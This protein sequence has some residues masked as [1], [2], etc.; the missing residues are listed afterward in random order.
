M[1]LFERNIVEP[2]VEQEIILATF[3]YI[4]TNWLRNA[5]FIVKIN[6]NKNYTPCIIIEK[7]NVS[8]SASVTRLN[9]IPIYLLNIY[10]K[11]VSN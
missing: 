7:K 3:I 5:G 8:D 1:P 11:Y 10:Y 9:N 6:N 2:A 4:Y